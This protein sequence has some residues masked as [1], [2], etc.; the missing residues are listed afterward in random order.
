MASRAGGAG[1]AHASS[2]AGLLTE[3]EADAVDAR[4]AADWWPTPWPRCSSRPEPDA[5]ELL[6]DVVGGREPSPVTPA[7][8]A[9]AA[10][11]AEPLSVRAAITLALD[12][13]LGADDRVV[14]LGE[15]ISDQRA[16]SA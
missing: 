11:D 3:A 6:T 8:A 15:D 5:D 4:C 13:A 2:S 7:R 9:A 14:L 12:E 16:C 1:S 10:A